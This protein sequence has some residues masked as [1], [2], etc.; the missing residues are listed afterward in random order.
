METRIFAA[1]G[2]IV[3]RINEQ[4]VVGFDG[5]AVHPAAWSQSGE[6][7]TLNDVSSLPT[8]NSLQI[9]NGRS[10]AKNSGEHSRSCRK[11][12]DTSASVKCQSPNSGYDTVVG[13]VLVADLINEFVQFFEFSVLF[14][15]LKYRSVYIM[16]S[17]H[18]NCPQRGTDTDNETHC[19]SDQI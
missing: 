3:K 8:I 2:S 7:G 4:N 12:A 10:K 18:G 15:R 6:L 17:S 16:I 5:G 1:L 13:H 14:Y 19:V 11:D 9:N